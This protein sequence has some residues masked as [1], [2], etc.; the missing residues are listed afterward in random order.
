M[1]RLLNLFVG[2]PRRE[3]VSLNEAIAAARAVVASDRLYGKTSSPRVLALAQLK[4]QG[5]PGR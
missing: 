1:C 2:V 4:K 5:E 3:P